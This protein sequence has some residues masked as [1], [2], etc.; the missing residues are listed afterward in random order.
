MAPLLHHSKIRRHRKPLLLLAL[1]CLV[2]TACNTTAPTGKVL[3]EDPRGTVLLKTIPDQSF[4][5]SHPIS[6]EPALLVQILKGIEI[7]DQERGLQ[8]MLAGPSSSVPV[9][10]EDQIRFLAPLLAE[11][12]RKATPDQC[13]EYRVQTTS[14]GSA[15]ES[16]TTETT[17]GSLYTYGVSLYFSLTQYRYAPT[18]TDTK[19]LAHGRLPDST[20]LVN[21]VLIFTPGAAQRSEG[22]HR[23]TG[24]ASTDKYLAIDYQLLQQTSLPTPPTEQASPQV[25]RAAPPTRQ[26]L[27]GARPP[28]AQ[29]DSLAQRDAEIHTLKDLVV[30]KDLEMETLRQELQSV[31]KQLDS[32]TTKPNSQKRKPLPPSKPQ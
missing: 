27:A 12:L 5:T 24:V 11:G 23:P 31:R 30:K 29:S 22:F 32:Q 15:L 8:K 26:P 4:Q 21:R 28:D 17:A 6:L 19:N 14:K 16:S 10:S 3:F 18:R 13:V 20:G 2:C 9:F 1:V 7:Q 25:E